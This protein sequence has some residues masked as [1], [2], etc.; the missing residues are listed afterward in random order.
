MK[1][2]GD[3]KYL[4]GL[5]SHLP[6]KQKLECFLTDLATKDV[7]GS[8]QNQAVNARTTAGR[9]DQCSRTNDQRNPNDQIPRGAGE[10]PP[11]FEVRWQSAAP[12]PLSH[13]RN[14]SELRNAP[15]RSKAPFP[16]T[17]SLHYSRTPT[18]RF[19]LGPKGLR[20][21]C[22]PCHY[23][24]ST[25]NPQ[26]VVHG[27]MPN[28]TGCHGSRHGSMLRKGPSLLVCHGV[29]APDPPGDW[30]QVQSPKLPPSWQG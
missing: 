17:P 7:A 2:S 30:E 9:N 19:P 8:G 29:T 13:E 20:G 14:A 1:Y 23:Q 4:K 5:P 10:L 21:V 24:S 3:C 27:S 28:V 6:S 25:F 16:N 26:A 22:A 11:G 18:P 12:S 15:V